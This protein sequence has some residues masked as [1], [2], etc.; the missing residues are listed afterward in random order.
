MTEAH[1]VLPFDPAAVAR[2][3]VAVAASQPDKHRPLFR[4][5][6]RPEPYPAHAL[7]PLQPVAEAIQMVTQAPIE[8]C[9]QSVVA[10][11]ALVIAPH[12]DAELLA[13]RSPLTVI[14]LSI[15]ESGERKTTVDGHALAPVYAK[16]KRLRAD[17]DVKVAAYKIEYA[18][19][20]SAVEHA[21]KAGKN[22]MAAARE[23]IAAVGKEPRPPASPMLVAADPTAEGITLQLAESRPWTGLF[24][25]EGG[26]ML[27]GHSMSEDAKTRT[28]ALLNSFWDGAD[29]RRR[30]VATGETF[31]TGRRC[32]LHLMVQ[33]GVSEILTQDPTFR[34][35]GLLARTLPVAP[36]TT[37]GTRFYK[38]APPECEIL[39]AEYGCRLSHFLDTPPRLLDG[40]DGLDPLMLRLT[41]D[42]RQMLIRF[43]DV[44]ETELRPGGE[45]AGIRGF[46]SKMAE[47]AGR[48]AALLAAYED[49]NVRE[50]SPQNMANGITLAKFYAGEMLRLTDGASTAPESKL[51]AKLLAWWQ[52]RQ[53]PRCHI[54][55]IYQRGPGA[56]RDAKTAKP[57]VAILE[58]YGWIKRLPPGTFVDGAERRDSWEL[59][60]PEPRPCLH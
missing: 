60:P 3:A 8:L 9:A 39:L 55:E 57:I 45:Y 12:F 44:V 16:E 59:I 30:R 37:A 36:E 19:Y 21:K 14:C 1:N 28:S 46:A 24:S 32:S 13:G 58:E 53:D 11:A 10:A 15:A 54:S 42:A 33:P 2:D 6:A 5:A 31:L 20:K 35:I 22:G 7:G 27:G 56:I 38:L 4:E 25:A 40:S 49:P 43:H 51:A 17:H 41:D 23:A 48:L 29:I 18:A 52:A 50:I 47:H 34:D 26:M